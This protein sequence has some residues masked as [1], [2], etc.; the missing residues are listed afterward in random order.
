MTSRAISIM[1]GPLEGD[2]IERKTNFDLVRE[3]LAWSGVREGLR[4][5][6][7]GCAAGTTCRLI[8]GLVGPS[9]GVIGVDASKDRI[10]QAARHAD[11][12]P[13]ITYRVGDAAALPLEDHSVDIAWSRFLFEYLPDPRAVLREMTRATRPGGVVS[14]SDL[15]GN[16]V[17]HDGVGPEL[18]AE[19]GAAVRTLAPAFDPL[20]GR[21]LFGMFYDLGFE[22]IRVDVRPYHVIAGEI[23]GIALEHWRM[24]LAGVTDALRARGWH[25]GRADALAD[26]FMRLLRDPGVFT[27]SI[28]ITVR[29]TV[30]Q[31][32]SGPS[33]CVPLQCSG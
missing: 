12:D 15:D 22:D 24:K 30:P 5:A 29:G 9:G 2:R 26:Q 27:Y 16:C 33:D 11:H 10:Q 13:R 21:R 32:V 8:A 14:V 18:E 31:V 17:W 4:V 28:L 25:Q 7:I 6:D 19:I 3:Q 20:V 1:D 23:D